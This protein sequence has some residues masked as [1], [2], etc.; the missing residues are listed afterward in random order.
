VTANLILDVI[1]DLLPCFPRLVRPDGHLVLSGLLAHQV[2]ELTPC[3]EQ[4]GFAL[5][6]TLQQ[7]EW[8]CMVC[9]ALAGV[10]PKG[11][12]S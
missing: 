2:R 8:A 3:L 9:R 11:S 1:R 4:A 7:E 10:H 6:K 12:W 5:Q